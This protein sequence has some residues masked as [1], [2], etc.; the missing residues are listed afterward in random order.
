MVVESGLVN[1]L[2]GLSKKFLLLWEN[3][4]YVVE[5]YEDFMFGRIH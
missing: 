3:R 2:G 5:V 1:V 4:T